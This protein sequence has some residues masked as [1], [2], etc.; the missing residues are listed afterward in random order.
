MAP[1][2]DRPTHE[3]ARQLLDGAAAAH[4]RRARL[5]AQLHEQAI[6]AANNLSAPQNAIQAG[7]TKHARWQMADRMIATAIL[8]MIAAAILIAALGCIL[9]AL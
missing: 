6:G 4:E 1:W 8:K 5:I 7:I 2:I 9:L 3:A